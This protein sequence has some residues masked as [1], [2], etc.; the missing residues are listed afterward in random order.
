MQNFHVGWLNSFSHPIVVLKT[1]SP[2]DD[3]GIDSSVRPSAAHLRFLEAPVRAVRP[4]PERELPTT[5]KTFA[6]GRIGGGLTI[7]WS[8][9]N[10]CW[11][12]GE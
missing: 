3:D 2:T 12:W 1:G 10:A 9:P 8:D 11:Q 4:D 5:T 7:G 6:I